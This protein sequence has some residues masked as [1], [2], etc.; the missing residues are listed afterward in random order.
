MPD[1]R[2]YLR[3]RVFFNRR[4]NLG[5]SGNSK[6]P[7]RLGFSWHLKTRIKNLGVFCSLVYVLNFHSNYHIRQF[8]KGR[9]IWANKKNK[10]FK[11]CVRS[12][13]RRAPCLKKSLLVLVAITLNNLFC[14]SALFLQYLQGICILI[15]CQKIRSKAWAFCF[16]G[17]YEYDLV[18][19]CDLYT[20]RHTQW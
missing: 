6:I 15:N 1:D 18:L 11:I 7:D 3:F 19:D 5:R 17:S 12:P 16:S 8:Q 20:K 2:G 14:M 9:E 10:Q 4:K 13:Y